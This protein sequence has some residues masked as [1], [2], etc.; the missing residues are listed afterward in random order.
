[1]R[2]FKD[3]S[4]YE[5]IQPTCLT[6]GTFDGVHVGHVKILDRLNAIA[7]EEGLRSAMLTFHPHPRKVL[8]PDD[9]GLNLLTTLD[10]KLE[11]LDAAGIQ[12]VIIHP[13]SRAFSRFD[14]IAYVRDLLVDQLSM[15]HMVIGYDHR[16]G[17]NRKGD[18][19]QLMDMSPLYGF[20]V[21][22]IAVK[23][24]DDVN[25][26]STKIRRALEN[27]DID[28]AN[29]FLGYR[30]RFSGTVVQ[31]KKR[32]KGLGFPT[33]N[34]EVEDDT[35]LIPKEGVYAVNAYI[36]DVELKGMMNI[37]VNPTFEDGTEKTVEV[38][39]FDFS[40]E[41]YGKSITIEL[42]KYLR[43]EKRFSDVDALKE[44]MEKDRYDALALD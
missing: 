6:T 14:P 11:R 33:A 18:I 20:K 41:I 32:G 31:G 7:R 23:E 38:N 5:A 19:Q 39:L 25:V 30:Y 36:E 13:F 42:K 35:K 29:T 17:R 16:F 44:Q 12:D 4:N 22:E 37:G 34:I 15:Q 9:H 2:V 1:M 3:I 26:S 40:S 10:E 24:V 8:F 21:T 28:T 43:A 27:G